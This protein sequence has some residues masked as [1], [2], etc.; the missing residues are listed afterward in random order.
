M[1]CYITNQPKTLSQNNDNR[2]RILMSTR[3]CSVGIGWGGSKV[4]H[5]NHLKGNSPVWHLMMAV[6][7][8]VIWSCHRE[9]GHVASAR[10][11]GFPTVRAAGLPGV[12]LETE[13]GRST[14]SVQL[15]G[16]AQ[17]Q[18]ERKRTPLWIRNRQGFETT[19][20]I[21]NMAMVILG[22]CDLPHVAMS[23]LRPYEKGPR[24]RF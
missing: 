10:G 24:R 1:Y 4:G 3:S 14:P 12:C 17:F 22:K 16:P 21:G 9:H 20:R 6:C 2:L 11:L 23:E 8:A 15:W 19:C 7:W 18:R 5:W 13:Q